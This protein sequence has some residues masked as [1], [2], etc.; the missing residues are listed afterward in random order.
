MDHKIYRYIL[1]EKSYKK[2]FERFT[3]L[4]KISVIIIYDVF[5]KASVEMA[6]LVNAVRQRERS[7]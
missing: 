6:K 3:K 7:L 1:L 4:K 5:L 2:A